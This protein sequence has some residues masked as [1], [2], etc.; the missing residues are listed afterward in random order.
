MSAPQANPADESLCREIE[1]RIKK[2]ER[3]SRTRFL[4][5]IVVGPA[6]IAA[7]GF[8]FNLRVERAKQD[9]Q[10]LEIETRRVDSVR[11]VLPELFAEPPQRALIAE[12]IVLGIVDKEVQGQIHDAVDSWVKAKLSTAFANA[13]ANPKQATATVEAI[14][15]AA[16]EVQS[17]TAK[18]LNKYFQ[19]K[20]F[21]VV[22]ESELSLERAIRSC[23]TFARLGYQ[24]EVYSTTNPYYAVVIGIDTFSAAKRLGD[25]AVSKKHAKETF[26]LSADYIDKKVFPE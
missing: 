14:Q 20:D 24:A 21:Y 15:T 8:Y 22:A 3:E 9:F 23:Q 1:E 13:Q 6:L 4:I 12:K 5:Q 11:G 16:Q 10:K 7:L 19:K 25:T 2:L 18:N 17:G 26:V